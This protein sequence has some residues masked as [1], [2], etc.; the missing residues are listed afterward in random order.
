MGAHT[1]RPGV[2]QCSG[3]GID[4]KDITG[5]VV[6][7]EYGTARELAEELGID[8][9]DKTRVQQFQPAFIWKGGPLDVI[10]IIYTVQLTQTA[11]AF[12]KDYEAFT[13]QL[14]QRGEEPEFGQLHYIKADTPSVKAFI[15]KHGAL[16]HEYVP[17]L[18]R[19][20]A[21]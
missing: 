8:A 20:A 17:D 5:G 4:H 7:A 14:A 3:G 12:R 19:R 10:T 18:L 1:S 13:A 15:Q 11:E 9:Y 2:I 6:D 16:L 21:G